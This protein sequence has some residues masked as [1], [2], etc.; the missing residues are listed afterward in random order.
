MNETHVGLRAGVVETPCDDG[1]MN[2]P[3]G[4]GLCNRLLF[5]RFK[6]KMSESGGVFEASMCPEPPGDIG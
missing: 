5:A 3:S 2:R 6:E 4:T 1:M